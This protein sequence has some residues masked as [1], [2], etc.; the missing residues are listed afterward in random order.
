[1]KFLIKHHSL[2]FVFMV[3][4]SHLCQAGVGLM[5]LQQFGGVNGIGFYVKSLFTLAGMQKPEHYRWL[6]LLKL[7]IL[8]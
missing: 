3:T 1:M 2:S 6:Y 8:N 5:A 4:L 7:Y